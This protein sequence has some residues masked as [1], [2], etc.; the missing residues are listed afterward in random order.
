M[1]STSSAQEW[2]EHEPRSMRSQPRA[3]MK[4]D[5]GAWA[6]TSVGLVGAKAEVATGR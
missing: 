4:V 6:A 5:D 3:E 2:R 1:A